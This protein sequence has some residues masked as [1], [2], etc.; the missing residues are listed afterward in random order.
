MTGL[1]PGEARQVI[2]SPCA[3]L[4][5]VSMEGCLSIYRQ[6]NKEEGNVELLLL[7]YSSVIVGN[8][9]QPAL[10]GVSLHWWSLILTALNFCTWPF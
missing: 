7:R 4:I 8:C 1:L 5:Y 6:E 9:Y 10:E 2:Y 3:L